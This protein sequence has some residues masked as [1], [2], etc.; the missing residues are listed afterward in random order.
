M[1]AMAWLLTHFHDV[2]SNLQLHSS[3]AQSTGPVCTEK[4]SHATVA[5]KGITV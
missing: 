4:T 2:I 3:G 5:P 1:V